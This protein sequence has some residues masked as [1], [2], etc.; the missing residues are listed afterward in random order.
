MHWAA[1]TGVW[2][3]LPAC[4]AAGAAELAAAPSAAA[5]ADRTAASPPSLGLLPP[6][7]LC[8]S[9]LISSFLFNGLGRIRDDACLGGPWALADDPIR[10][11]LESWLEASQPSPAQASP[12]HPGLSA[13]DSPVQSCGV[14]WDTPPCVSLPSPQGWKL[15]RGSPTAA[16]CAGAPCQPFPIPCSTKHQVMG[17]A[18]KASSEAPGTVGHAPGKTACLQ[19]SAGKRES[20]EGKTGS[21]FGNRDLLA[22]RRGHVSSSVPICQRL[23]VCRRC[24]SDR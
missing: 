5:P 13:Q 21:A 14:P 3:Q 6:H 8:F 11:S 20:R 22:Q 24:Q 4:A 9:L 2:K 17:K 23:C 15:P 16:G 19:L 12:A 10:T 1:L 7:S 18:G